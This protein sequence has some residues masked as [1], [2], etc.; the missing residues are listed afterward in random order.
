M[1]TVCGLELV[2]H[3]HS[4]EAAGRGRASLGKYVEINMINAY[5]YRQ[6]DKLPHLA[7]PAY[8]HL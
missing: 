7:A 6:T 1:G 4:S 3:L 8:K 2:V 5:G